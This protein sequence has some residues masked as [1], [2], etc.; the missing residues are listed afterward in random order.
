MYLNVK[1]NR[2]QVIAIILAQG[3]DSDLFWL[4]ICIFIHEFAHHVPETDE[5]FMTVILSQVLWE[6]VDVFVQEF[7]LHLIQAEEASARKQLHC[8]RSL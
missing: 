8:T 3:V 2:L 6:L 4:G 7:S 5:V 1:W